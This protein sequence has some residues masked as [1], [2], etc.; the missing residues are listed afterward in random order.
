MKYFYLVL[1]SIFVFYFLASLFST[2]LITGEN[3]FS[4]LLLPAM[5]FAILTT[6]IP[7]FITFLKIRENAGSEFVVSLIAFFGFFLLGSYVLN[8]FSIGAGSL[9]LSG[10]VVI[11][12]GDRIISLVVLSVL[13]A[14]LNVIL[15][16]IN[17]RY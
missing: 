16:V 9:E 6:L 7:V 2:I 4:N 11:N 10:S 13:A 12:I 17:K 1:R 5:L 15:T 3:S 8:L 14:A